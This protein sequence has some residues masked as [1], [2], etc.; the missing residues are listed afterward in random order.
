MTHMTLPEKT[1]RQFIKDYQKLMGQS[2][3]LNSSASQ[4]K[5]GTIWKPY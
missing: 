3:L 1:L 4:Q 5:R 2:A